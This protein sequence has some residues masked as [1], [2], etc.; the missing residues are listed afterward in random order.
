[1]DMI[2]KI[3]YKYKNGNTE[4]TILE[5]GT[6]IR[7]FEGNPNIV[8]PE[9]LDCKITDYCD[10][11]CPFCHENSTTKGKH[12]NLI[13][14]MKELVFL[15]PG[16]ELAIGGGNPLSHPDLEDFLIELSNRG[17]IPNLTVNSKHVKQYIELIERLQKTNYIYGLGI[18]V[19]TPEDIEEISLI[20][21]KSNVVIH[22]I[23]GVVTPDIINKLKEVGFE[24]VL[25]LGYK[26][27]GRGIKFR[28]EYVDKNIKTWYQELIKYL[29]KSTISFDNLAIEQLH[30]KR[31]L[32]EKAWN[33][34]YM[35]DD[36]T[37]TMYIDAVK[38]EYAPTSRSNDRASFKD[39]SLLEYFQTNKL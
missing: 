2:D 31:L 1:M 20:K 32:T 8:H 37:F 14:L 3:L 13:R 25:L 5:D 18:S 11:G 4:V 24:K 22:L 16:V 10:L 38:Q 30:L 39:Y 17:I 19:N 15:P 33:E 26:D 7:Q 12:A 34:F 28:N 29:G 27:F 6:K 36:F 35:G 21:D 23:I 9:S